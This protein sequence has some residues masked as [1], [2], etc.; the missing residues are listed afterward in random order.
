MEIRTTSSFYV[1]THTL[2]EKILK[3][4]LEEHDVND[5]RNIDEL[6]DA[7]G[8]FLYHK[9]D[10]QAFAGMEYIDSLFGEYVELYDIEDFINDVESEFFVNHNYYGL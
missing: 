3:D 9:L 2:C 10:D 5:Y 4:F 1:D 7:I 8:D 6:T